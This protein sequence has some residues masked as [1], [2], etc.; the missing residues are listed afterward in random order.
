MNPL[1]RTPRRDRKV[2]FSAE[3]LESR[4]LLTGGAGNT[5]AI[6]P[7]S[8][9]TSGQSTSV[10]FTIDPS[11]FTLPHG[12]LALGVDIVAATGSSIKPF[13]SSI[14][15]PHG[16]LIPQAFHSI[17]D[18]HLSHYQVA[19][20]KGTNAVIVP[21]TFYPH[22]S[23]KPATYTVNVQGLGATTGNFLLGFYLPGDANGDG[24]VDKT[25]IA[26]VKS[27]MGSR[28]NSSKYNFNADVNRDGRIGK[29]DLAYTMQ[30]QGV[31]VTINPVV[32]ADLVPSSVTNSALRT[33]TTPSAGFTGTATPGATITYTNN[34][35]PSAPP[36]TTTANSTGNYSITVPLVS[37]SNVFQVQSVDAFGQKIVGNISPVTYSPLPTT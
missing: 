27:E 15:D 6:I 11:H 33:T 36:V 20:G 31:Q 13:I 7:G 26:T 3:Q 37:G 16:N 29:I 34:N 1:K 2:Q 24:K 25:D 8:V 30:N 28:A 23:S 12:K 21:V 32:Q 4:E 10:S 5:F 18:P 14:D 35:S 19:S 22:D 9:T 17:Y